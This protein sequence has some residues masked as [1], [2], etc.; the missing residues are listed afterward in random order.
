MTG[1]NANGELA[2]ILKALADQNRLKIMDML[3]CGELCACDLL[4]GL[5]ISQPTLS[6][7]MKKLVQCQLVTVR[8]EGSWAYYS[9][10]RTTLNHYL[11]ALMYLTQPK[12]DCI[13]HGKK[14]SCNENE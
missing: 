8:N 14:I 6:H 12:A 11:K 3:S 7:H 5:N 1:E 10:N 4:A 13:C 2:T 9:L